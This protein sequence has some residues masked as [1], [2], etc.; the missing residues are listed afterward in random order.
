MILRLLNSLP[1]SISAIAEVRLRASSHTALRGVTC[2]FDQ[3][4]LYLEGCLKTFYQK[5]L[6]QEIV[7]DIEGVVQIINRIEVAD[8]EKSPFRAR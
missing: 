8:P 2:N 4:V 7:A 1:R 6:A 3:G 5:Q